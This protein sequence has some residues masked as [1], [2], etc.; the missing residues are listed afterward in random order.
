VV[1]QLQD[2]KI[3]MKMFGKG[4]DIEGAKALL[5]EMG[6]FFHREARAESLCAKLDADMAR[7]LEAAKGYADKP[8][9]L[10]IHFGQASNVWLLMARRNSVAGKMIAWAGGELAID[11][12]TG[13]RQM[14]A[15][16]VS[17]SDPDVILLTDFGYDRLGDVARIKELPGVALTKAAANGRI[18][19]IDAHELI[20]LGP[21]TGE[22]T[23]KLQKLIHGAGPS[24]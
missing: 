19:R 23:L 2:L 6:A 24:S 10:V 17:K 7:A 22:N 21:R 14:S 15:E 11:D 16:A 20:Y 1:R 13:M 5:R 12:T 4:E 3:P 9:V 18:H 8:K